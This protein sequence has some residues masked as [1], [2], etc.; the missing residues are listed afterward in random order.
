MVATLPLRRWEQI[1]NRARRHASLILAVS[2][3][4][5]GYLLWTC[6][7][8]AQ[9]DLP[10][11]QEPMLAEP[12]DWAADFNEAQIACYQGSM[13]ACDS[14]WKSKRVLFGTWLF[15]YGRTCG[16]RV[17]LRQIRRASLDCTEAFPGY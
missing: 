10:P 12:G 11:A 5:S 7:T 2:V 8:R 3:A 17:D 1:L 6:D 15:N 16:G 9:S 14:I 13:S 4:A